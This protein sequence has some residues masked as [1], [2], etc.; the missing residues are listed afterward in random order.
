MS[1]IAQGYSTVTPSLVIKEAAKAIEA[2]K[3]AFGATEIMRLDCPDTGRII[4]AVIDIGGSRIMMSDE[5]SGY[6]TPSKSSFYVYMP[7]ADAAIL[8]AKEAGFEETMPAQDMFWGDRM[9]CV[10]DPFGNQWNIATF[11]R[12]VSQ[13]EIEKGAALMREEVKRNTQA[14]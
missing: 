14:A 12:E 5:M 8:M 3:K 7:D 2:Y 1:H 9:G 11:M 10:R 6:C 13:E 4:H